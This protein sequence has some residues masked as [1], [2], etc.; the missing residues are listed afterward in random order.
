M[1]TKDEVE[2]FTFSMAAITDMETA[3]FQREI[4]QTKFSGKK[5]Y[6]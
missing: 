3:R 6:L 1:F 2:D 4:F 5:W